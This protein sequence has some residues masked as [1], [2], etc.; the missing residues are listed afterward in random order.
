MF[1]LIVLILFQYVIGGVIFGFDSYS[2][3][4]IRYN[5][6]TKNIDVMN[7]EYY[8]IL[9]FASKLPMYLLVI[10]ISLLLSVF[11]NNIGINILISLGLYMV[12]NL[13][14]L[15]NNITKY[16]FMYNWDISKYIFGN[17]KAINNNIGSPILISSI[18]II[19]TTVV[20]FV[21][22]SKKD[23]VNE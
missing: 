15:F 3:D 8:M 2:L 20:L 22:F 23:I 11:I 5:H 6:I 16:L 1:T 12:T 10:L 19:L 13:E 17:I 7:L 4:A 14:I 21:G 9:I 18:W